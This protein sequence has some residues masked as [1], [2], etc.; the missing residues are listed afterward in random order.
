MSAHNCPANHPLRCP[1]PTVC[2]K[3]CTDSWDGTHGFERKDNMWVWS[4]PTYEV[5]YREMP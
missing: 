1:Y 4:G 3:A 2:I 5:P